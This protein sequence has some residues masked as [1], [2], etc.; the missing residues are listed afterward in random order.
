MKPLQGKRILVTAGP[1]R[2]PIDPVRFIS[3]R[4]SGKMGY[5]IAEA[6][7]TCGAHVILISGPV[8]LQPPRGIATLQVETAAQMR[9]AVLKEWRSSDVLFM[10]AA[11]SDFVPV[12]RHRSKIKKMGCTISFRF[13]PAPDILA[14]IGRLKHKGQTVIGFAAETNR[15]FIHARR[16]LMHKK[17]DAIFLNPVEKKGSGFGSEHNEGSLLFHNGRVVHFKRQTKKLLAH[18]LITA[19]FSHS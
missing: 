8:A 7:K 15:H 5:A 19:I 16:K 9:R 4:S 6:A 11:V 10:V 1:T 3:N 12:V 2:E 18:R 14:E 17:I 13:K